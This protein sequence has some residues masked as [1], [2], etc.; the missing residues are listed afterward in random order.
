LGGDTIAGF[1]GVTQRG[2]EIP[3]RDRR[4]LSEAGERI[5]QLYENWAKP[6]KAAEW[7]ERLQSK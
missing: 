1:R 2:A 6:E 7:R 3:L 4:V 5:V